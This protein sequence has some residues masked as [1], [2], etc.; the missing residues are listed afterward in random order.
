MDRTKQSKFSRT[1]EHPKWFSVKERLTA[2][3]QVAESSWKQEL[4]KSQ[5][6]IQAFIQ[7]RLRQVPS[8]LTPELTLCGIL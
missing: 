7:T 3:S 6:Q 8:G 5:L 1:H 2:L 4:P